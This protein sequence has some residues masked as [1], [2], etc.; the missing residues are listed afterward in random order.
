MSVHC[1]E[2]TCRTLPSGEQGRQA[3]WHSLL[4]GTKPTGSFSSINQQ[5]PRC[6]GKIIGTLTTWRKRR[7]RREGELEEEKTTKDKGTTTNPFKCL[8]TPYVKLFWTNIEKEDLILL[9]LLPPL[10]L[11]KSSEPT[12]EINTTS[13]RFVS[14]RRNR[15]DKV[16]FVENKTRSR[17]RA[18]AVLKLQNVRDRNASE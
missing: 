8:L 6:S 17:N 1:I 12:M 14:L 2:S 9:S 18:C 7:R 4:Y 15:V 3:K 5:A 11:W 16:C 10:C 13:F